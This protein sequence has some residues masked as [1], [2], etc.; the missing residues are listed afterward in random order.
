MAKTAKI[1]ALLATGFFVFGFAVAL[2]PLVHE[3]FRPGLGVMLICLGVLFVGT[4]I[5]AQIIATPKRSQNR[6]ID[7]IAW[8]FVE[9]FAWLSLGLV[10]LAGRHSILLGV[11]VFLFCVLFVVLMC[12][13]FLS[14][15]ET[16]ISDGAD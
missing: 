1:I 13:R 16:I 9:P 6:F 12:Q 3:G 8:A 4:G 2:W 10:T 5:A 7:K 15:T 14:K 11:G